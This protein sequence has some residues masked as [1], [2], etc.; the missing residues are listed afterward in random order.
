MFLH[1]FFNKVHKNVDRVIMTMLLYLCPAS[2]RQYWPSRLLDCYVCIVHNDNTEWIVYRSTGTAEWRRHRVFLASR[3][4]RHAWRTWPASSRAVQR[5]AETEWSTEESTS[6]GP[7]QA[8]SSHSTSGSWPAETCWTAGLTA[9]YRQT[10]D[11]PR[12]LCRL[13]IISKERQTPVVTTD[14]S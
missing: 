6:S 9:S 1:I 10:T 4:R 11:T 3:Q 5:P 2:D 12:N 7:H 8:P 14:D 13:Q